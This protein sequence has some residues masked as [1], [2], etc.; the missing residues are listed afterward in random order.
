[1]AEIA[2]ALPIEVHLR[3]LLEAERAQI[4]SRVFYLIQTLTLFLQKVL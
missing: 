3:D 1:M 2:G 4:F